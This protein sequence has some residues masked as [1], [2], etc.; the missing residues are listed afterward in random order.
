M[1]TQALPDETALLLTAA[2]T[3]DELAD[4]IQMTY[5][6]RIPRAVLVCLI[7]DL[8]SAHRLLFGEALVN[9]SIVYEDGNPSIPTLSVQRQFLAPGDIPAD[10]QVFIDEYADLSMDRAIEQA[11]RWIEQRIAA[12]DDRPAVAEASVRRFQFRETA[13]DSVGA[14][15]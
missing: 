3:A 4:S 1:T 14:Q 5:T 6:Q 2:L 10:F 7:A 9:D 13:A 11:E 8:D 15:R 12:H